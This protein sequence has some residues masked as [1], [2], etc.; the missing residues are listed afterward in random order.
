MELPMTIAER[1]YNGESAIDIGI[2][3][4]EYDSRQATVDRF[5]STWSGENFDADY[6][7]WLAEQ[8]D[9]DRGVDSPTVKTT[10]VA[11]GLQIRRVAKRTPCPAC[12]GGKIR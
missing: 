10:Q 3:S 1:I 4:T 7:A 2:T 9:G 6:R 11:G 5:L 8:G 12:G